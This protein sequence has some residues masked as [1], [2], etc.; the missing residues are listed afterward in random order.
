LAAPAGAYLEAYPPHAFDDD[1]LG[2]LDTRPA[3]AAEA[4]EGAFGDAALTI[5]KFPSPADPSASA[6]EVLAAGQV[7]ASV[8]ADGAYPVIGPVYTADLDGNGLGDVAVQADYAPGGAGAS[9][10]EV[11]L[12][13]QTEPG[14]FR[15]IEYSTYGFDPRDFVD[16]DRDGRREVLILNLESLDDAEG[17]PQA[18]WVYR[19][20]AFEKYEL[21]LAAR[22]GFPKFIW[23]TKSPNDRETNRLPES[24][25]A[26]FLA[27]LEP[28]IPSR[29]ALEKPGAAEEG[30]LGA[31]AQ[32]IRKVF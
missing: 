12:L 24:G 20:Y 27:G 19:L 1:R 5:R 13:L 7:A 3:I 31:L 29:P 11:V 14:R 10:D 18:F 4:R 23:F 28:A 32:R 8:N 21:K 26:A 30:P 15:R 9:R 6:V 17:K 25:K 2:S 22:S 16:P